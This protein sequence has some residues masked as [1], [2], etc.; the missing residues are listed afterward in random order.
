[1]DDQVRKAQREMTDATTD[2]MAEWLKQ[3]L[4]GMA[5]D[6]IMAEL[7]STMQKGNRSTPQSVVD[8]Y[9]VMG[10]ERTATGDQIK[11]QYREL[12]QKLHPDTARIRGTE[13]LFQLVTA[14]Y[15]QI[16]REKG[17]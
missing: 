10:L 3:M 5:N 7:W 8:P 15:Q 11:K 6:P 17:L 14:A 1:M 9:R 12:A 16:S 4:H 2:M 13:F